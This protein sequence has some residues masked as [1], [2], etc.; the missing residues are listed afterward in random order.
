MTA[1][2]E[3]DLTDG[4]AAHRPA[5]QRWETL[6]RPAPAP[7]TRNSRGNPRLNPAFPEWMMGWPDGWVTDAPIPVAEQL[8]LIGNGVCP[9]Q[10][11]LALSELLSRTDC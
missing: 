8:H 5:I 6:T 3:L 1:V 10:A 2:I 11:V 7:T 4:W 9:Q